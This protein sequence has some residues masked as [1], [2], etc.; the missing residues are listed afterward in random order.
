MFAL[1]NAVVAICILFVTIAA[2]GAVSVT[3]KSEP[4]RGAVVYALEK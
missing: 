2:V 1:T 4:E 3:V